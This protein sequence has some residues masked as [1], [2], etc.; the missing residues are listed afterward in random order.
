MNNEI[1]Y[2]PAPKEKGFKTQ[3]GRSLSNMQAA[4][5]AKVFAANSA[6]GTVG[7]TKQAGKKK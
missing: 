1:V 3:G 2:V 7:Q 4:L 6:K 5:A